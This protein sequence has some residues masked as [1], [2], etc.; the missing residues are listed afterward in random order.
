MKTVLIYSGGLD[1]T[2]LLNHLLRMN[3]DVTCLHF[4]YG[5]RHYVR[6]LG[7]AKCFAEVVEVDIS[8]FVGRHFKSA[9][10]GQ[11]DIPEGHYADRSMSATVVPFRNG[12]MLA[13]AAGYAKSVG[14]KCLAIANHSGDHPIYPDCREQ[15]IQAMARAVELG[16]PGVQIISPFCCK[17]KTDIVRLGDELGVAM[18][19]TWS[20]YKGGEIHCGKCGTCYERKEAFRESGVEDKT[21]Y[22][23]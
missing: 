13:M 21:E 7:A 20:C 2:V 9:L 23:E 12:I 11:G 6:E 4:N 18:E 17:T 19:K 14:A 1:S 5:Q 8:K 16:T 15:F 22:R 10:L 3:D